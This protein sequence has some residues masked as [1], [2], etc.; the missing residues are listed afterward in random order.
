[1]GFTTPVPYNPPT[2]TV[3]AARR[4]AAG[5]GKRKIPSGVINNL[6]KK[7]RR[8]ATEFQEHMEKHVKRK[9]DSMSGTQDNRKLGLKVAQFIPGK[10]LEVQGAQVENDPAIYCSLGLKGQKHVDP[11]EETFARVKGRQVSMDFAFKLI[12]DTSSLLDHDKD[13]RVTAINCFRHINPDSF[14]YDLTGWH[15][16]ITASLGR[17]ASITVTNGGEYVA[18]SGLPPEVQVTVLM[19]GTVTN[20]E[21]EA[22][23]QN[24]GN[25]VYRLWVIDVINPGSG[26]TSGSVVTVSILPA[27][28]TQE[29]IAATATAALTFL[30]EDKSSA[31]FGWH[32]TLGPDAS[33]IRVGTNGYSSVQPS[34]L[35]YAGTWR[36]PSFEKGT[37]TLDK[38]TAPSGHITA[39][40]NT[41]ISPFRYPKD[42][43]IMYS[44]VNR[45]LLENYGWLLNPFKFVNPSLNSLNYSPDPKRDAL[46]VWSNP[47]SSVL[48]F[49]DTSNVDTRKNSYPAKIN[50]QEQSVVQNQNSFAAGQGYEWHSQFGPGKLSYQFSNDGTNPVCIDIC[51]VGVKKDSPSAVAN[52]EHICDYNYAVHKYANRNTTDLNGFQAS[53][54]T[55]GAIDFD[56]GKHEWHK[57]AKLPFMPD[58]CFKNPQSFLD[59]VKFQPSSFSG[60]AAKEVFTYLEQ[61]KSNPFK[62][63]KRDQ[64]IV[65]SGSSRAWNT[66]LPSIKYRPQVYDDIE[67]PLKP[68]TN[69]SQ[70]EKVET[71]SDEYTFVL[72]IG[73][74]GMPKP[75][76]EIYTAN[77][78]T[79]IDENGDVVKSLVDAKAI[80]D[81]QPSTC[82]VSVVGTYKETVYPCYP[83]DRTSVNF[84]N[85]RLTEPYFTNPPGLLVPKTDTPLQSRVNTVDIS[86]LGQVVHTTA[87]GIVGVGAITTEIGA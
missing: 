55:V 23:F 40:A 75:V 22:N 38:S 84:I 25:N 53:T 16:D 6:A 12:N 87:D 44:R 64:F 68:Q 13:T 1:M 7:S 49:T 82:N 43:E 50:I 61:G 58:E 10:G 5:S 70:Q 56:L 86:Q 54:S 19:D 2:I 73:A 46:K 4:A 14:N 20:A 21:L 11:L 57:N 15:M 65:S 24:L 71:T 41:L 51:V 42:M 9:L 59:A 39:P 31:N 76:E 67:Y 33:L 8:M 28:T 3:E 36:G 62:L 77:Q 34:G 45:Q 60:A 27:G 85:G 30:D 29:V 66:T 48:D 35:S 78:P 52:L 80:I 79:S 17:V 74:S 72:C 47:G 26:F 83:Q 18:P 63:V 37:G 69:W 32:S 81:R